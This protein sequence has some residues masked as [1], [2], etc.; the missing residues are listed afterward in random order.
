MVLA[1]RLSV[2]YVFLPRKQVNGNETPD[3]VKSGIFY[4]GKGVYSSD[5]VLCVCVKETIIQVWN[6]LWDFE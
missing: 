6:Q 2:L 3:C 5:I 1:L 4:F